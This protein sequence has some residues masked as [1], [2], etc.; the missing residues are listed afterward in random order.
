MAPKCTSVEIEEVD[1][2][3]DDHTSIPPRNPRNV[4]EAADSS[5]DLDYTD[6][7]DPAP[8]LISVDDEDDNNND[9]DDENTNP[10]A[11]EE[12]ANAELSMASFPC[13]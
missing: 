13:I 6:D 4:L 9:D 2:K 3:S 1:D 8:E 10:E 11:P 7:L 12:S 5:D